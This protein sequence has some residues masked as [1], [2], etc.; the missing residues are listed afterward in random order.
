[1]ET[2]FDPRDI[3]GVLLAGGLGR[4]MGGGGD[5]PLRRLA[6]QPLLAHAIAR[7]QPQVSALV[8][9]VNAPPDRFVEY[10]LPI[11][12]DPIDGFAGP[13]AGVLAG[14]MWAEQQGCSWLASFATDAPFLPVD[15]VARLA[16]AIERDGADMGC[17]RSGGRDHPVFALWPVRLAG[18]LRRALVDEDMRKM[19]RWTARY[20]VAYADWP[21]EPYDPFFNVNTPEDLAAAG[22]FVGGT[23]RFL[24]GKAP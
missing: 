12:A 18:A 13:L 10:S 4:R 16:A 21:V 6:G 20:R 9:N 17:A 19:D 1:M 3:A 15:L 14:M 2:I 5:K 8:L 7:A 22:A 11:V 24:S 23:T